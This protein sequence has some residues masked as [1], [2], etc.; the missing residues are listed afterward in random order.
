MV[1]TLIVA[2]MIACFAIGAVMLKQWDDANAEKIADRSGS[3]IPDLKSEIARLKAERDDLAAQVLAREKDCE[4]LANALNGCFAELRVACDL[5][6]D[7]EI[8]DVPVCLRDQVESA[9]LQRAEGRVSS[10][11]EGAR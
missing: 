4:E 6:V 9:A 3:H 8:G 10:T 11:K 7:Y 5:L 1:R 2:A